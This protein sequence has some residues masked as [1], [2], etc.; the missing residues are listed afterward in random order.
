VA[1]KNSLRLDLAH[2]N[3]GT[4]YAGAH[5]SDIQDFQK[6][7]DRTILTEGAMQDREDNRL[8]IGRLNQLS[9]PVLDP[10]DT[11]TIERTTFQ[12]LA[13][14]FWLIGSAVPSNSKYRNLITFSIE[15]VQNGSCRDQRDIMFSRPS[16]A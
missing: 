10:R 8:I 12:S 4:R 16:P 2:G 6:A 5:I 7:L 13:E 15:M 11:G 14:F 9:D 3:G 1:L